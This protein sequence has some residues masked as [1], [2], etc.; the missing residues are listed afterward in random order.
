[1]N[2]PVAL[3]LQEDKEQNQILNQAGYRYFN[4]LEGLQ[5]YLE[6]LLDVGLETQIV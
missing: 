2:S 1:V 3:V 5:L 4:S 6:K